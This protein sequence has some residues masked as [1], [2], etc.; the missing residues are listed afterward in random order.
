MVR[1]RD[2]ALRKSRTKG[3]HILKENLFISI[4]DIKV[5]KVTGTVLQA[6]HSARVYIEQSFLHDKRKMSQFP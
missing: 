1:L 4:M 6:S 3:F 5:F 2:L